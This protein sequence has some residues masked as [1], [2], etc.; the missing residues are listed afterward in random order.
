MNYDD[1]YFLLIAYCASNIAGLL[2][3]WAAVKKPKHARL[4]FFVLFGWACWINY[5]TGQQHP[6]VYLD[7]ARF[8]IGIYKDFIN[9]WFKNHIQVTVT[10]IA[11]GQ[12]LIALGMLLNGIWVKMACVGV[13]LFLL[14]IAPLGVGSA[15]PFSITVS[16]AAYFI[17]KSIC[18]KLMALT[19][20]H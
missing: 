20:N 10:I 5:T 1:S 16:I 8:S 14:A 9:G 12:A 13:I 3:L 15:F 18:G 11:I 2:L 7:Y 4:V 17:I 6:Q 19:K